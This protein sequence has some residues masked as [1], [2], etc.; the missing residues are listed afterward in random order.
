MLP[1]QQEIFHCQDLR[2]SFRTVLSWPTNLAAA[3]ISRKTQD[4]Q[5]IMSK[6]RDSK[7]RNERHL[8]K[9]DCRPLDATTDGLNANL[10]DLSGCSARLQQKLIIYFAF[11]R[12]Y[13][14]C[15]NVRMFMLG[16]RFNATNQ[17]EYDQSFFCIGSALSFLQFL[18]TGCLFKLWSL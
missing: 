3:F 11:F 14:H 15:Q 6:Q 16:F 12:C 17:S 18:Y 13:Q 8:V 1:S 10:N 2:R 5:N 4:K 7:M 9:K